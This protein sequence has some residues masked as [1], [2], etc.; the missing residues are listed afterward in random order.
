M[1]NHAAALLCILAG[2]TLLPAADAQGPPQPPLKLGRA[3]SFVRTTI[4]AASLRAGLTLLA[5]PVVKV[6]NPQL[7]PVTVSVTAL[8]G[9]QL[10]QRVEIGAFS[11]FP[12]DQAGTFNLR[13][14]AEA[15]GA[16]RGV[17]RLTLEIRL[18]AAPD[19]LDV[20]VGPVRLIAEPVEKRR[21]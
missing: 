21:D 14:P 16:S 7:A 18:K 3:Q 13:V 8:A 11:L 10:R 5:I 19:D 1:N 4:D 2:S 6:R 15:V 12:A 17:R 20:E 9:R